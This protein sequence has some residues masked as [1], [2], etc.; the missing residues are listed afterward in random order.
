ML[1]TLLLASILAGPPA[2]TDPFVPAAPEHWVAYWPA[3]APQ[4]KPQP[5]P[6][7]TR[8]DFTDTPKPRPLTAA[9]ARAQAEAM[10]TELVDEADVY[11]VLANKRD[12]VVVLSAMICDARASKDAAEAKNRLGILDQPLALSY[13]HDVEIIEAAE[14]RLAVLAIAPLDCGLWPVERVVKCL[15]GTGPEICRTDAG[16]AAQVRAAK[17]LEKAP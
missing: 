2:W 3:R 17:I 1:T 5:T 11:L 6:R 8:A 10:A 4:P 16:L 14:L 12:R 13:V 15:S 7:L 9:D